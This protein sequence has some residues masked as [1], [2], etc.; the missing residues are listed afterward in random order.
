V[1]LLIIEDDT[2]L[3]ELL[4]RGLREDG[5]VVDALPDGRLCRSYLAATTYDALLLDIN[6]PHGDG[7]ALL[8]A[9]RAAGE[10]MS[11]ILLTAR[12][13]VEDVIAGLDAGADDYVRKPFAFGELE[14]RLRSVVRRPQTLFPDTLSVGD[15]AF[16]VASRRARRGE[17]EIVLTA[18]ESAL[19]ELLM[20]HQGQ[21]VTRRAIE[22]RLWNLES[23]R[24]SNVLDVY[25]RRLRV[26]LSEG[27]EPQILHTVRGIGYRIRADT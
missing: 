22:E 25:A 19:L 1:R 13:S 10:R 17:R 12:D 11:V 8:R 26:K 3:R 27:G 18:K 21:T 24:G 4:V 5:H 14:A 23:D 16:D 20:R 2:P 15:L 9:L 6:L 7:L